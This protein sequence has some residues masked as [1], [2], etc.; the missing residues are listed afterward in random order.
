MHNHLELINNVSEYIDISEK[1]MSYIDMEY[2]EKI[3]RRRCQERD[4][5]KRKRWKR[6]TNYY[7]SYKY[8]MLR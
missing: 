4:A 1:I 2:V 6:T 5:V 7:D 3:H 8:C